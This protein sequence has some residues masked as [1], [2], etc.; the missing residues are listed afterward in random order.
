MLPEKLYEY[1]LGLAVLIV[2]YFLKEL[3][4][5]FKDYIIEL[6]VVKDEQNN[7]LNKVLLNEQKSKADYEHLTLMTSERLATMNAH[8]NDVSKTMQKLS[9]TLVHLDK[10]QQVV[11]YTM[12]KFLK[13]EDR[14]INLERHE[15][16]NQKG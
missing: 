2:A 7:L 9:D 11:T 14:V 10:N 1:L 13:L 8:M 6:K 15:N 4:N 5:D 16:N 3:H 12:E